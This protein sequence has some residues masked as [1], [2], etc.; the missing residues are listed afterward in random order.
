MKQKLLKAF[1]I[2][3]ALAAISLICAPLVMLPGCTAP[4][5]RIAV[6]TLYSTHVTVDGAFTSYVG[7]AMAGKVATN[8]VPAAAAAYRQFQIEYNLAVELVA[9]NT[10]ASAP[11]SVTAAASKVL[12]LTQ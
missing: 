4:Q 2:L 3:I 5:Q 11:A 12:S 10:N 7:L 6:N 1:P 9:G 8:G